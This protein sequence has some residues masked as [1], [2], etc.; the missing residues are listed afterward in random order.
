MPRPA[1]RPVLAIKSKSG[2]L[3]AVS[4]EPATHVQVMIELLPGVLP[5]AP[6]GK[7]VL[8]VA[9]DAVAEGNPVW[10]DTTWLPAGNAAASTPAP[11]LTDFDGVLD[12]IIQ[13]MIPGHDE[14]I[15]LPVV[16]ADADDRRLRAMREF[17]QH[18]P[19]PVVVRARRAASADVEPWAR[20]ERIAT[21]LR[22]GVEDLHLVF[23]EGYLPSVPDHRVEAL[24]KNITGLNARHGCASIT[25]LGGSIPK[26][27][28]GFDTRTRE[29]TE[30]RLWKNARAD[31]D[32]SLRYG[33]YGVVHPVPRSKK[34][35]SGAP[36]PYLHYTVPGGV[37][38]F[39]RHVPDRNGR[40][41]P[42]GAAERFF[43]D[44]AEELVR[45]PEFAGPS[46]SWGDEKLYSCRED[47]AIPI[48][49]ADKWIAL[50]TSHHLAHLSR[51]MDAS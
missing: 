4:N 51:D 32:G 30:I 5:E 24:G 10:L 33:D 19:R 22:I 21:A 41:L 40:A 36:N 38:S 3:E 39:A 50:A 27:R 2:E 25:V 9:V 43:R 12:E 49:R 45:R 47:P 37:L 1:T 11:V 35:G 20:I 13:E 7:Q 18:K 8:N 46:F 6:I 31:C 23:D 44:V 34:K 42:T 16:A 26:E 48:G 28:T 29:R 15:L 17:L 14:P